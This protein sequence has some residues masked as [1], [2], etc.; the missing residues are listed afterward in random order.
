MVDYGFNPLP[1]SADA[2]KPTREPVAQPAADVPDTPLAKRIRGYAESKLS[3]D[4]FRHSMRV[5][6]Y[7][8]AISKVFPEWNVQGPLLETYFCTA[9]LHDLGTT[10]ENMA[11]SKL[12]YEF[13]A[14]YMAL[15]LLKDQ[16]RDQAE[17]VAEAIIRHQDVQD[18]GLVSL[19][20]QMIQLGTLL[21]NIGAE[22]PFK[23]VTQETIDAV[24]KAYPRDGWSG[25][26]KATV[27][28]EKS[29]KPYAMVSRIEGF[30][31]LI[32]GN[33]R[34]GMCV[35]DFINPSL[36]PLQVPVTEILSNTVDVCNLLLA[37]VVLED[38][39]V[40]CF[41]SKHAA[42]VGAVD[43]PLWEGDGQRGHSCGCR[44][45]TIGVAVVGVIDPAVRNSDGRL[46]NRQEVQSG[47]ERHQ[48]C[49]QMLVTQRQ[50]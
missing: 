35:A 16:P 40:A 49:S 43:W 44:S 26:F 18:K 37:I 48:H 11:A 38:G 3:P 39:Q 1:A 2:L 41:E 46:T 23:C 24:N 36:I 27:E 12:S 29:L 19:M 45:W 14:G 33:N 5:Y 28:K 22:A 34:T 20:T 17:S 31:D 9:M 10:D 7:G 42:L 8:V 13:Y 4:T 50:R 21:D 6:C 30:E 32:M 47:P 25:C 15:D